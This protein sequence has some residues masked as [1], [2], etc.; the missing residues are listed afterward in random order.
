MNDECV[1]VHRLLYFDQ[2]V[3]KLLAFEFSSSSF[4][5]ASKQAQK[6]VSTTVRLILVEI[7]WRR[8]PSEPN[9][10]SILEELTDFFGFFFSTCFVVANKLFVLLDE[11]FNG[12][13]G[14]LKT[15]KTFLQPWQLAHSKNVR[16]QVKATNYHIMGVGVLYDF[17][18]L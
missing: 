15:E 14:H 7:V 8:I 13:N 5:T 2:K 17:R 12:A 16:P 4:Q 10:Y 18:G 3:K 1:I 9:S 11:T 6:F